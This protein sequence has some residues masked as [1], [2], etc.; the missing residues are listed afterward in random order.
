MPN[1]EEEA[2]EVDRPIVPDSPP[3]PFRSRSPSLT[4]SRQGSYHE[5]NHVDQTL[6]DTF[7]KDNDNEGEDDRERLIRNVSTNAANQTRF[8]VQLPTSERSGP[9]APSNDGVFANLSAKPER[10]EKLEEHPPVSIDLNIKP[11]HT[12]KSNL[13][14]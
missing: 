14:L 1:N 6:E 5:S 4:S 8:Q 13:V 11:S 9:A 2:V 10:G 12:N 3:P 7:G